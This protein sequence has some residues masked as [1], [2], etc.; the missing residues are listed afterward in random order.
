MEILIGSGFAEL[1]NENDL[2]SRRKNRGNSS[3]ILK[4]I[5]SQAFFQDLKQKGI[6]VPQWSRK[7]PINDKYLIK[8]FKSY[9]GVFIK[10]L[11]SNSLKQDEYYQKKIFGEHLS[12]QFFVLNKKIEVLTI[13]NQ[14]FQ[15]DTYKPFLIKGIITKKINCSLF[16]KLSKI[17]KQV[18]QIY[19]LNGINNL[20]LIL[21][22]ETEKIYIAELNGR[23]GLSTNLIYKIH[24]NIYKDVNFRNKENTIKRFFGTQIIYSKKKILINGKKFDFIK[25][26]KN[27][28]SFSEL[29]LENAKINKNEPI[30][31]IHLESNDTEKL[32]KKFKKLSYII[33][34]NLD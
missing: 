30:C 3:N 22:L 33:L 27:S 14:Y 7:K 1:I 34:N 18:T 11:K 15:E 25:S 23:P 26:L 4:D 9:G 19:N 6:R 8:K 17:C 28:R 12:I 32:K 20:D 31:L 21:E 16:D 2:I 24:R 5:N 13:C 10:N 29:P